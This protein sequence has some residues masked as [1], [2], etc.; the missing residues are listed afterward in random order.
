MV[1]AT[2]RVEVYASNENALFLSSPFLETRMTIANSNMSW[3]ISA[4]NDT[5]AFKSSSAMSGSNTMLVISDSNVFVD[6]PIITNSLYVN[7]PEMETLKK[8]VLHEQNP[9]SG[10]AHQF[11]GFGYIDNALTHQVAG[12]HQR[13]SFYTATTSD[14]T[15][16][17]MRISMKPDASSAQVSI[18]S[19]AVSG[20]EANEALRVSGDT[21]IT[22][23]LTV[24]GNIDINTSNFVV[25]DPATQRINPSQLPQSVPLLDGENKI[26]Q[27][28]LPAGYNFQYLRAQ[29]NVGIGTRAPAQKLHVIGSAVVS[30]RLGIG[31]TAPIARMHIADA[32]ATIPSLVI[33]KSNGGAAIK[34]YVNSLPALC[35]P[36]T[37]ACIG[38]GT[39]SVD[40]AYVMGVYGDMDVRGTFS[41]CNFMMDTLR[42]EDANRVYVRQLDVITTDGS[43]E[44]HMQCFLPFDFHAGIATSNIRNVA[45]GTDA[46]HFADTGIR[47]DKNIYLGGQTYIVSDKNLKTD[48]QI[49]DRPLERLEQIRGYTYYMINEDPTDPATSRRAGVLAQDVFEV[50]PEAVMKS[51]DANGKTVSAVS[52]DSLIPLLI[53]A[54]RELSQEINILKGRST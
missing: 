44:P 23:N 10:S 14:A 46:V 1:M 38:V 11:A 24:L 51:T 29:K 19:D 12:Y 22:G 48:L 9:G 37:H 31:T 50:L 39:E 18:G 13:H 42:V 28:L 7:N 45:D 54:V 8:L 41:A 33:E 32:S 53:E 5:L 30:D 26:D 21:M 25:V 15:T 2:P 34:T 35:I 40:A 16:E 17:M 52:Y 20:I 49:I 36:G 6:G 27:S 3:V 4:S 47:V 43:S